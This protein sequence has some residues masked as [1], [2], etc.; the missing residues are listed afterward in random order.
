[1]TFWAASHGVR[2]S[3]RAFIMITP[4]TTSPIRLVGDDRP[5][6]IFVVCV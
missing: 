4:S 1:M 2:A 3:R 6:L 5:G